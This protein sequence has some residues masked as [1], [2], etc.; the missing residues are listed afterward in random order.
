MS[1]LVVGVAVVVF[2]ITKGGGWSLVS[3]VGL[4][5]DSK[6]GSL[7]SDKF[8]FVLGSLSWLVE[9]KL[10]IFVGIW[11]EEGVGPVWLAVVVAVVSR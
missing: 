4:D 9:L 8:V 5:E 3:A 10:L 6:L 7:K 1:S 11:K 2:L